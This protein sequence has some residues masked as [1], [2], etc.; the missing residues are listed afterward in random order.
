MDIIFI[1]LHLKYITV[2]YFCMSFHG[3]CIKIR[4]FIK[5]IIVRTSLATFD[6]QFQTCFLLFQPI[7]LAF[8]KNSFTKNAEKERKKNNVKL[9]GNFSKN[10]IFDTA[11]HR[12]R[13][14]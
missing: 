1:L 3:Y 14:H 2:S 6:V 11:F 7:D 12:Y 13:P 9:Q 8:F 4:I 5:L 10:R